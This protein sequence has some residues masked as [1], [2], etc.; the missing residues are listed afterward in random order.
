MSQQVLQDK[1]AIVTGATAGIGRAI[2]KKF[3]ENG[4]KV[5][6]FGQNA[7]R[8]AQVVEEIGADK[9]FFLPVHVASTSEVNEAIKKVEEKWGAVSILV[10]NA[11]VTKDGLLMKM[12]EGSWDEVMAINVKSCYNACH[13]LI[14]SMMKA[15]HGKIINMGSVVGLTG[16]PGQ[17]NYSASKAAIVGFTKSL[18]KEVA[19]RGICVNCIAPGFIRSRMTDA[20]NEAQRQGTLKQIPMGRMGEAEEIAEVALFLAGPKSDYITG[21]VIT[22]DGG[23]A[24]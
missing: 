1:V 9:A 23:L 5:A 24:M 11:G 8:G 16:N 17:T 13:A 19:S 14:R 18:A 21:Q 20:L 4:A 22:V 2:A 6:L 15:R 3:A 12:T 7:E 10:N